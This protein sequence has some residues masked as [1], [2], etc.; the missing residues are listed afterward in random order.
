M[1]DDKQNFCVH[2]F[3]FTRVNSGKGITEILSGEHAQP[4]KR[5]LHNHGLSR[6]SNGIPEL[7]HLHTELAT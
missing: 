1:G 7:G 3:S 5:F 2:H 4:L 6:R